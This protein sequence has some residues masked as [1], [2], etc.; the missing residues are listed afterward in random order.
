[1]VGGSLHQVVMNNIRTSVARMV[2]IGAQ[3]EPSQPRWIFVT[4]TWR[5]LAIWDLA[6]KKNVE[7][8]ESIHEK[9]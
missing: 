6:K 2:L 7:S 5:M 3:L 8:L 9:T 1:V 4:K